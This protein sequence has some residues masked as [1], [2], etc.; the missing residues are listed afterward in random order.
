MILIYLKISKGFGQALTQVAIQAATNAI[1]NL[2]G[3]RVSLKFVN[4]EI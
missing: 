2:F 1:T 4:Q 3:K